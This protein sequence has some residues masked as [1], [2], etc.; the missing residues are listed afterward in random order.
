MKTNIVEFLE[1][2][3]RAYPEKV[4][5]TDGSVSLTYSQVRLQAMQIGNLVSIYTQINQ[6]VLI[7]EDSS[8]AT[9]VA[10][11][12]VLYAGCYFVLVNIRE[13]L[14]RIQYIIDLID[15]CMILTLDET[16][17]I[18]NDIRYNGPIKNIKEAQLS[19]ANEKELLFRV[20]R[21]LDTDPLCT[22]FTSG[23]TGTPK[24]VILSHRSMIDRAIVANDDI[25]ATEN[26]ILAITT[27]V[28]SVATLIYLCFTVCLSLTIVF[29]PKSVLFNPV[30]IFDFI[31]KTSATILHIATATLSYCAKPDV[32][33]KAKL[34]NVKT[35]VFGGSPPQCEHLD[36][37][38][39]NMP[40]TAFINRYGSTE[41]GCVCTYLIPCTVKNM[42]T[43]PLGKV[44]R[45]R[46]IL[47]LNDDNKPVRDGEI[48]EICIKGATLASGYYKK[49][50]LTNAVFI[51][52]PFN[53]LYPEILYKSGD[54]GSLG[55]DGLYM[56]HGRKDRMVK[57]KGHRVELDE[58]D[59]AVRC[60]RGIENC[61]SVY[62]VDKDE[63]CL[64][65][66]GTTEYKE[67]ITHLR[68]KL[69]SYMFPRRA[70]RLDK[71]PMINPGKV[72][73]ITL[74]KL[75]NT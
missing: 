22:L 46:S 41:A 7:L 3:F 5:F 63:I 71:I 70:V 12:G 33:K 32:F 34:R 2:S 52:N 43:L 11:L 75:I 48:G 53:S 59:V 58:I 19:Q 27:P 39:Q 61:C 16:M 40:D 8:I 62:D 67:I 29:V 17:E 15:P 68:D 69:P 35:V 73:F 60:L 25:K 10:Y 45:N 57:C 18:T 13:P 65:Y 20:N 49:D 56:F 14:A 66:T 31:N 44:N 38:L 26:D 4:A 21:I 51:K 36:V 55:A 24:G 6:P 72:D 9:P 1:D 47:L 50:D 64:F 42:G 28:Y 23:S 54:L 30:T 37:W 74:K